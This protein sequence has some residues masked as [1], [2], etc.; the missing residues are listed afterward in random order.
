MSR[1]LIRRI[2]TRFGSSNRPR[3]AIHIRRVRTAYMAN[4]AHA[5]N[6]AIVMKIIIRELPAEHIVY[7][8][9]RPAIQGSMW[10]TL[11]RAILTSAAARWLE[12]H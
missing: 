3:S 2:C 1:F 10:V 5:T 11:C 6:P 8:G 9:A 4:M 12:V 7:V